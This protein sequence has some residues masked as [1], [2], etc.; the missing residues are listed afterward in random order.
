[1][2][3]HYYIYIYLDPRKSGQYC[4]NDI[5]FLYEPF[6]VG[7]GKNR[8]WRDIGENKRNNFFKNKINKIKQFGLEPL[9]F[10]LYENLNENRSFELEIELINEIK[11]INPKILVNM[12]YGG[13]GGS[14]H[15][16]SSETKELISKKQRKNF[17]DVKQEFKKRN[18][19]LL[20]EENEYKN[21]KIKLNCICP[22]G[23]KHSIRWNSFQQG[24]GCPYCAKNKIDFS[25]IK[26][27]FEKRNYKLL[28]EEKNYKNTHQKLKYICPNGHEGYISWA[29]FQR[30]QDCFIE[31][32]ILSSEKQR[33]N[34]QEIKQEFEKRN[35]KLLTKEK[36]YKNC[37]TKLKYICPSGHE[38]S[39]TWGNFQQGCGCPICYRES[40]NLNLRN[41]K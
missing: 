3:N 38:G 32:Y 41:I 2:N 30:G 18:Y 16:V 29:N 21:S 14:G 31:R 6:Y 27:E 36:D 25:E 22:K 17:L 23:H 26:Q 37:Y 4:Y 39:I 15:I 8:R 19:I 10:K 24:Q 35:Y 20:T 33:K 28:T 34:Y 13:E 7:K 5:C 1:M 11:N 40:R 12:T 9:V